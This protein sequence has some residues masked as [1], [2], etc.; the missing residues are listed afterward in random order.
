MSFTLL[1]ACTLRPADPVAFGR[2]ALE[3]DLGAK[4]SLVDVRIVPGS[5]KESFE[6]KVKGGKVTVTGSDPNGA[7]YGAL[8]FAERVRIQ[9]EKAWRHDVSARPFLPDRGLNL[10]LTLPWNVA[11]NDTDTDVAALT[12][13][14]RWW[15]QND[16]YWTSLLDLMAESRLNWLDI[17]GCWDISV[18]D[19]PNLYAYF[20][21]SPSFPKVGVPQ[22]VKDAN[23]AR[24]NKVIDMAHARGI[25]VSLMSYQANLK[26]PQN[27][28][29]PYQETEATV[30]AYTR[31]AVEQM[32][33]KAP[34][35]DA[36][37][38]RIGE[39]GKSESFFKCY[40]E[41][42][43][44]SGKPIPLITRSWITRRQNVLPLA[45]ASKDFTVEIKYNGE[46]WGAPYQIAGGRMANWYSYSFEDYLS[47]AGDAKKNAKTWPGWPTEGGGR[48][49]GNPYKI[50]WQ[51]RANGTHRIFP[52]HN[53]DWVRRSIRV[54][55]TGTAS[56][57]TIEGPDAYYPK[58][59]LYYLADPDDKY[60]DWTHQRDEL[61]WME[62]GRLGYDPETPDSVFEAKLKDWFGDASGTVSKAWT[63]ASL[64]VPTAFLSGAFGS[65]HRD[66]APELETGGSTYDAVTLRPL[67]E[68]AV[69][70]P[71]DDAMQTALGLKDGRRPVQDLAALLERFALDAR[72]IRDVTPDR[73]PVKGK[74]R[75][76]EIQAAVEMLSH[77]GFYHAIK[78]ETATELA[79]SMRQTGRPGL[80]QSSASAPDSLVDAWKRLS[81]SPEARFYR[82]FTERLRMH[83]NT[84]H[85]ASLLKSVQDDAAS[86]RALGTTGVQRAPS[87]V[88]APVSGQ[89][90]KVGLSTRHVICSIDGPFRR[91]WLL[92][93][94]L[95]SST[96]FHRVAMVSKEGRWTATIRRERWGHC[97][98]VETEDA[99][100][101]V[102]RQPG[103][104]AGNGAPYQVVP[105]LPGQT[106]Q[107]YSSEEALDHLDPKVLDPDK[108][109]PLLL[110]PRAWRFFN[111]FDSSQ[112][113]KLLEAVSRG[114]DLVV[115]QQDFVSGRYKL[116]F[117][118]RP[119]RFENCPT[120]D[121]F[122]PSGALGMSKTEVPGVLWQRIAPTDG[123][124]VHGNGGV[125]ET[126]IGRGRVVVVMARLM[127][128][129]AFTPSAQAIKALLRTIGGPKPVVLVD[130]GTEGAPFTT[131][132]WPDTMNVLDVPFLTLGEVVALEQGTSSSRV[133]PGPVTDGDVLGGKGQSI[134]NAY[135]RGRVVQMAS[136]PAPA[137][138]EEADKLRA[139]RKT[140]LLRTL[141]LDPMPPRTPLNAR[142]TGVVQRDGYTVE[143]VVFESSPRFYVT[144]HVYKAQGDPLVRR[145]V[146]VNVNG[147]WAHKKNEDRIQLRCAFQALK[148]YIAIA[149]DSPGNSF[150][151]D[152]LIERRAEGSH[153][154]FKLVQGGANT[155]GTYVWD[156]F[157]ALDY[158]ATRSDTDVSRVGITG[159]SGGGLATLY[160]FAADDRY[161]AAVPVV[162]MS[163][164]ETAP[165]NGCPCNHVPG[166]CQVGDRSDVLAVQAPKPV[167]IIGAENDGEFPPD[168]MRRTRDKA[169]QTWA[170]YGRKDDVQVRIFPGPHDYNRPM[171]EAMIGFFDRY[172]RGTG[173]GGPV[174][175][176]GL[177]AIDPQD[178]SLLVLD[179]PP[180]DER[181]MEDLA[182]ERLSA[183][184]RPAVVEN[185]IAVNGGRPQPSSR[186]WTESGTGN[187]RTVV[188]EP[189]PGLR[190]PAVLLDRSRSKSVRILVD[191]RGKAAALASRTPDEAASVLAL[192]ILG[193]G[194]LSGAEI[195]YAVYA[196]TSLA[197]TG[198]FQI[199][200]AA[201][202]TK[203]SGQAL[204]VVA[205]GPLSS[206]AAL[207]AALLEPG[208]ARIESRNGL[209]E[210]ADVFRSDVPDA[211]IQP[212]ANLCGKLS[213]YR[214]TVKDSTWSFLDE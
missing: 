190:T 51:V 2:A 68:S 128:T 177:S 147:H 206:L 32:V 204:T 26:I 89:R 39:S 27:R 199:L 107:I 28:E 150:E 77:L 118:P 197:F 144:A 44:R 200:A 93:K 22:T 106:P 64:I 97:L 211:A 140:E 141:G 88:P 145:P 123:W 207:Y 35:L 180:S 90:L 95:P 174:E 16:S 20:V 138:R 100:G 10:F 3:R 41:A 192:D 57:Y 38:F 136:R 55:R 152:S 109:G 158:M 50:V 148:G 102:S 36:I 164:M 135:L 58:D 186:Q 108:Y 151:G 176:P 198:A 69:R 61:Y 163:S 62:W 143:K 153:F 105:S 82:P 133:V 78:A 103:A 87:R 161:T 63:A 72:A 110:A 156:A 127:Q 117:L 83:T 134:A 74:A 48:W 84:F 179:P 175:Q 160:A 5:S 213:D 40:Q 132:F 60:C 130:A 165:E 81:D 112:K 18:T 91:A 24:L 14:E 201:Q 185:L 122:D 47:D 188:F 126:K 124:T 121:V 54:M 21:T 159:A 170:L 42:V 193:T 139:S 11:K 29:V 203:R 129:C 119:P 210:W 184:T 49:P 155:T 146:I 34:G 212:R 171:R 71:A 75:F 80:S 191:D 113:R 114:L 166:T 52:F 137:S 98:A 65:D 31:E 94:P 12:D 85:W 195:R 169:A 76:K 173:D 214:R 208:F 79:D 189:L 30:Y 168:A 56:G 66:H 187:R 149:I 104:F 7:M 125:A 53:P 73:I 4:A 43:D 178:R 99:R 111:G 25:R 194:E 13:P 70:A 19:A 131:S 96:F 37:G 167:L 172:L 23:L 17:H 182:R 183:S 33:R 181:T 209:R 120:P 116:D 202:E 115:L 162:Y 157:R 9:G 205:N 142:T 92:H 45:R 196:G 6:I 59:P 46:Q 101:V 67:D 86:L 15:F 154:E 1:A 8:E